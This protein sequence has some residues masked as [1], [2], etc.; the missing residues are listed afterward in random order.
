[1]SV[2]RTVMTSLYQGQRVQNVMHFDKVDFVTAQLDTL[3]QHLRDNWVFRVK[4]QQNVGFAYQSITCQELTS[5]PAPPYLLSILGNT[6]A[7]AGAGYH[8]SIAMIFTF[9]TLSAARN[10]RG[11]IYI[12]GIHGESIL[13]GQFHPSVAAAF[14]IVASQLTAIYGSGG[15]SDFK[16]V[17]GPRT[18]HLSADFKPVTQIIARPICGIQRRRNINVGA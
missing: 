18:S 7:L 5:S 14:A 13:N 3:A 11:R 15:S 6:G 1:M 8:P 17:I 9:R 10:G 12:G 2:I 4:A 16:L